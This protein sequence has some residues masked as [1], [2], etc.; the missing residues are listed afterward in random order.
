MGTLDLL[1][2]AGKVRYAGVSNYPGWQLMKAQ[3][4]RR[5]PRLAAAASRT[6]SIIR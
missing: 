6:R 1:I 5:P 3:A 4:H 2:A